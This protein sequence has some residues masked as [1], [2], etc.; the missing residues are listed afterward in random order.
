MTKLLIGI[1]LLYSSLIMASVSNFE[2]YQHDNNTLKVLIPRL[3]SE[4]EQFQNLLRFK[5]SCTRSDGH[6]REAELEVYIRDT[7]RGIN[8]EDQKEIR[9]V[10]IAGGSDPY[11]SGD[12]GEATWDTYN[13]T[14]EVYSSQS[15][16]INHQVKS[17]DWCYGRNFP[18]HTCFTS[19]KN[20]KKVFLKA[21][22]NDHGNPIFMTASQSYLVKGEDLNLGAETLSNISEVCYFK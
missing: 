19:L 14:K 1:A 4:P 20:Q 7:Q 2:I 13:E 21:V 18:V 17:R 3:A 10:I 22:R 12:R 8:F 15:V 16:Y 6:E 5:G 9:F 11:E